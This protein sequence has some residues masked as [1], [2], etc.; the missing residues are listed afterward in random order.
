[1]YTKTVCLTTLYC[2]FNLNT[3]LVTQL[4]AQVECYGVFILTFR[5]KKG[6]APLMAAVQNGV[7]IENFSFRPNQSVPEY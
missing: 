5:S 7:E 1:M 6:Y 2:R 3:F 4:V